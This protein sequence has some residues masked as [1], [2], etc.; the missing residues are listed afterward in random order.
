M[1]NYRR[2]GEGAEV[3]GGEAEGLTGAGGGV[4][5]LAEEGHLFMDIILSIM[6]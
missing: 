6:I 3:G 4:H 5:G 2:R 1:I